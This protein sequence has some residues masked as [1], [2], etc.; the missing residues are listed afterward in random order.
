M[1]IK[2]F[3]IILLIVS[4]IGIFILPNFSFSQNILKL[5]SEEI[6]KGWQEDAL[7][8]FQKIWSNYIQPWFKSIW[9]GTLNFA[10][11]RKPIIEEELEKE[12][13]E[14]KEEA[15]KIGKSVWERFRELI[16]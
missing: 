12:K 11:R 10:E 5:L 13:Q 14:I 8:F 2:N 7:P 6:K 4:I 15:P 9:Q 1:S 3:L 16:K